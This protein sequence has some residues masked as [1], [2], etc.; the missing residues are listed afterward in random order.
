MGSVVEHG[1]ALKEDFELTK[2][3]QWENL[4]KKISRIPKPRMKYSKRAIEL[5]KAESEY[6]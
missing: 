4:E 1:N 3:I 2:R 6:V 5:F